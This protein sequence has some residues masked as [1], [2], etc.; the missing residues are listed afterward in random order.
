MGKRGFNHV[1][2]RLQKPIREIGSQEVEV[3]IGKG[4]VGEITIATESE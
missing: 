4:I 1:E 3:T 2:V